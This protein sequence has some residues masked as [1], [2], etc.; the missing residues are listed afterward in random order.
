MVGQLEWGGSLHQTFRLLP[1]A[2]PNLPAFLGSDGCTPDEVLQR[3]PYDAARS[4]GGTSTTPDRKRYRDGRHVYQTVG[5]LYEDGERLRVTELGKATARWVGNLTPVN[6]VVLG[7]HAAYGLSACQLRN[8]TVAG[9]KY[10]GAVEVF[11]FAYIWRAMIALDSRIS[12]AELNR[13]VFRVTNESDLNDAIAKIRD[14]RESGESEDSL[15]P[16]TITEKAKNDRIIAWMALASF[17]WLL[18]ADKRETAQAWYRIRGRAVELLR[19]AS[20]IKRVHRDFTSV[21]EYI[22]HIS[23]AA[24]LPKD[25]R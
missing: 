14:W 18:I 6:S 11:P 16:E 19:E 17:G 12:S 23:N 2:S 1:T 13:V 4:R 10:N 3:L 25:V 20:Q 9:R 15:G 8:P 5:L 24:C 22:N 7:R 21:P